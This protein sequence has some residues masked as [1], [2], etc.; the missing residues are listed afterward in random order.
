MTTKMLHIV[1]LLVYARSLACSHCTLHLLLQHATP[2]DVPTV[3]LKHHTHLTYIRALMYVM[4]WANAYAHEHTHTHTRFRLCEKTFSFVI[5]RRKL[6]CSCFSRRLCFT[7]RGSDSLSDIAQSN[8]SIYFTQSH[9]EVW[10]KR[11]RGIQY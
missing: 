4:H 6:L 2:S 7:S 5:A 10:K 1:V 8:T 3:E 9:M 11:E